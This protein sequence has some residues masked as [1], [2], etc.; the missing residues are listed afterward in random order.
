MAAPLRRVLVCDPIAAGWAHGERAARWR[1]LGYFRAPDEAA[2][3][4]AHATLVDTLQ[5]AGAEVLYLPAD[6]RLSLDAVYVH[7]AS[8]VTDR[9]AVILRM[10]KAARAS[11]PA[12]HAEV[13]WQVGIP[14]L[15]AIEPPASCEGGDLVW[16]DQR[17]LLVGRSLRTNAAGVAQLRTLLAPL[18]VTVVTA[19]LPYWQ[20]PS[21]CLHLMSLLSVLD[22][23]VALV[24]RTWLAVETV[25]WLIDRG[26]TLV[27]IDPEE[28]DT[29]ACNVLALGGRRLVAFAENP[30]TNRRLRDAGFE[31]FALAG[32][33]I[34]INGAGGPTCL[35]RPVW[36]Q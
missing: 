36:R 30:R 6:D 15:G 16:I 17:T 35:T 21:S 32:A 7:D 13:Y 18:G 10:G 9:G 24:D 12:V 31:V 23:R 5:E 26:W 22:E 34:G 4:R 14:L 20:G 25:E 11:E 33:E 8:F 29:L 19:P 2:A 27:D 1:E 28:R 3:R